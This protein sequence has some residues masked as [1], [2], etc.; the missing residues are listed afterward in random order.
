MPRLFVGLRPPRPLRAIAS[1]TMAGVAGARW[2]EDAQLH[3]TLRFI[4]EVDGARAA[5][6]ADVLATIR[7][8][9]L[10]LALALSGVG[11]FDRR[12]RPTALWAGVTAREAVT[13]LHRKVDAV[14]MR[15][16]IAP[17]HR[18]FLPHMTLAR[19]NAGSGPVD[20]WIADHAALASAEVAIDDVRLFESRLGKGGASYTTVARY[21]FAP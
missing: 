12:G 14:L 4:G 11:L 13:A 15:I 1:A 16:G 10:A 2:Q 8:P 7:A 19:L 9:A 3:V 20:R 17:D 21:P 18:A 5:D 6:I